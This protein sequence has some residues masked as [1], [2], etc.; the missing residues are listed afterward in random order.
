M[1]TTAPI[2]QALKV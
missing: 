1:I 2:Y